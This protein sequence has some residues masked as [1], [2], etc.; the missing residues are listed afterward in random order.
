MSRAV[1]VLPAHIDVDTGLRDPVLDEPFLGDQAAESLP[2]QG[3][4]DE[5]FQRSLGHTNGP[6]AMVDAA[7]AK[8]GLGDGKAAA[9]LTEQV[10]VR[11][12]NV[13]VDDLRM[14]APLF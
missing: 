11:H 14:T 5:I 7:W 2:L 10:V 3:A 13:L 4:L 9:F 8:P 12:A 1:D 6:H